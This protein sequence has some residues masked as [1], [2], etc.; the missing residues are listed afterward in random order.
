MSTTTFPF[1]QEI[2]WQPNPDWIAQSN[3]QQFMDRHGIESYDALLARSVEDIAWFWDAVME[4]LDIRFTQPYSQIVDLSDG[5]QFPRWC[6]DGQMNIIHNCL[7][8]W[9]TTATAA[10]TAFIWEGEE[11]GNL[12]LT[13]AQLHHEVCRCANALRS[14]GIG[15][16][17][18]VGLFMPMVP[19]LAVA[20]LAVI[21][22]GG[23]ILPLFSGYGPSAISNRLTDAG[24]KAVF[25]ADGFLRRGQ[26]VPMKAT[27]D[28][29]LAFAPSVQ[30]VIVCKRLPAS[31]PASQISWKEERDYWWHE[32][33][34]PQPTEAE[35]APTA[36]EDPL[37][38][39]YTSG[40]TGQP[41]G[42]VHTH[43]G[44][45]IKGAQDMRHAMDVKPGDRVYWMT[46][47]GWMMGPWLV[48]G[49]L[50]N[51]AAMLFFDGA[52]DYPSVDRVWELCARHRIT[53]LGLSPMLVRTLMPHGTDLV[54]RHDLSQLRA[55]GATG[56]PWGPSSWRWVF[57]N[58]LESRKPILNYTG[59]TEISGGILAGSF[60][61]PLKPAS[62][63]GPIPGMDADVVDQSGNPVRGEVGDLIIRQPW[64]GMTRGFWQDNQRYLETYWSRFEGVWLHGDF[65]AIDE[66]GMWYIL[67][68]SDDT[69]NVAGKRLGPAEV[70]TLVNAHPDI[71]ESAAV[72]VPHPL[73]DNDVVVFAV[74]KP[75]IDASET[76]RTELQE[77]ITTE[78]GRPLR[79]KEVRFSAALPKT[80][81]AK[82]MHRVIR[83]AYLGE[84]PG[85]ISAL[86]DPATMQAIQNSA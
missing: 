13:Y 86:E 53:L 56:S 32:L 80:R 37:M 72:A 49:T 6:V 83:A 33:V 10:E 82:V 36:A 35:T 78:L 28:R 4:D 79:P 45:P 52:G 60:F 2:A 38:I 12:T 30:H 68:R 9:Q 24:A 22:I 40:T 69:I 57:E 43:C 20:F 5:A 65:C 70:E 55:V 62:F 27:L 41:K 51:G 75:G 71:T 42:A 23:I 58:V 54:T 66:D 3:L 7:D 18:A 85:N 50:L 84:D 39:I 21:K 48:L 8:K 64:I 26:P 15:K 29:A 63:G 77:R 44:F 25:T 73:K 74:L 34:P 17:D 19:E 46:D 59:G 67:G 61:E 16:G 81:N 76:L 14:L 31:S 1:G 47:M 11:G